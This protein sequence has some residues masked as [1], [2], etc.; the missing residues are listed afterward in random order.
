[1]IDNVSL[2]INKQVKMM[3]NLSF[4][5]PLSTKDLIDLQNLLSTSMGI[6]QIY[7]KD[8]IDD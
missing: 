8:N 1:M 6:S 4:D 7:F 5:H 2:N 3:T